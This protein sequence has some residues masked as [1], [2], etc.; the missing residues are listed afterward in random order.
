MLHNLRRSATLEER[1]IDK[2]I[3]RNADVTARRSHYE[4][5]R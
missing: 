5:F 4:P 1:E 2:V 3:S